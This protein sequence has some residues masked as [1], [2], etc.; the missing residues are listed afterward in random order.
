[1]VAI[2]WFM[3]CL[4]ALMQECVG[5]EVVFGMHL[6]MH[7]RVKLQFQKFYSEFVASMFS[8]NTD[9]SHINV[10]R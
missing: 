2:A 3:M 4:T 5:E 9:M 6:F 1:M 7:S 10:E 8:C